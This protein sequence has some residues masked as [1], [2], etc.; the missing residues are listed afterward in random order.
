MKIRL[1][2]SSLFFASAIALA[3]SMPVSQALAQETQTSES[4]PAAPMTVTPWGHQS[5]DIPADPAVRYGVLSNGMKYALQ[6]MKH[7]GYGGGADARRGG[8]GCRKR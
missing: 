1:K 6:K 5:A 3:V 7:Q 4:S 2:R 8:F